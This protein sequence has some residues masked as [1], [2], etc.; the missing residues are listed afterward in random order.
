MFVSLKYTE[1]IYPEA[2]RSFVGFQAQMKTSDSCPR[3]TETFDDGISMLL[4]MSINSVLFAA[5]TTYIHRIDTPKP[6][7][8]T[9]MT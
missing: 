1:I 8:E 9:F 4:S 5:H 3:K 2:S 6:S 7:N